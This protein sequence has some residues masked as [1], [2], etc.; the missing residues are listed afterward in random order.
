MNLPQAGA[1]YRLGKRS[2]LLIPGHV[3]RRQWSSAQARVRQVV[4]CMRQFRKAL[5]GR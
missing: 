5:I 3:S 4:I 1:A 2:L